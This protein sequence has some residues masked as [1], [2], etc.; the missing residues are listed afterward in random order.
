M[1]GGLSAGNISLG[2]CFAEASAALVICTV[3]KFA[4]G[5]P[6]KCRGLEL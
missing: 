5:V 3:C 1:D 2:V 4:V 6:K